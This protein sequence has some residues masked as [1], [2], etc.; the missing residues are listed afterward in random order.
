LLDT[1][2]GADNVGPRSTPLGPNETWTVSVLS[3]GGNCM[4][5]AVPVALSLNVTIVNPSAASY[6]T[7]FPAHV[8]RPLS[9]NLNWVAR[10]APTPNAVT[11][12]LSWD[13]QLNFY[14]FAG[15]VDV[16][17]DMVGYYYGGYYTKA[18]VD[19]L[20]KR[21][22]P[23]E[24]HIPAITFT[25]SSSDA[26]YTTDAVFG[27]LSPTGPTQDCFTHQVQL[28]NNAGITQLT[29][30]ATDS[31]AA[32]AVVRLRAYAANDYP[33]QVIAEVT[34]SGSTTSQNLWYTSASA[35]AID[36]LGYAL[37]IC[38]TNG[39]T[40]EDLVVGYRNP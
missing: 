37:E 4:L 16:V 7:L 3:N 12:P 30:Y 38:G 32:D 2:A 8:A 27:R 19:A 13:G 14:N 10:Q 33:G 24:L 17:A 35:S 31:V 22:T 28:P 9:S 36:A 18:E 26:T 40:F 23:G 20:L 6:L 5:P 11:V 25:P 29:V 1:R 15:T 34:T 39:H 21:G